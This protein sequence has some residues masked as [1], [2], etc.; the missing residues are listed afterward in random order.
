MVGLTSSIVFYKV[1]DAFECMS[2]V[3]LYLRPTPHGRQQT[4]INARADSSSIGFQPLKRII[5]SPHVSV[6]TAYSEISRTI[7]FYLPAPEGN[8]NHVSHNSPEN[9]G[10]EQDFDNL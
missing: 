4:N 6:D 10:P 5:R 9:L 2:L 7:E 1:G 8:A 3:L